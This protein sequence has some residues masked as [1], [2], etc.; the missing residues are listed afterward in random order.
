MYS[1]KEGYINN[2]DVHTLSKLVF[3]LGAGRVH[4]TDNID[5]SVGVVLNKTVGSKVKE[6]E[7]LAT[8]YYNKK[9]ADMEEIL[10]Q[11]FKI[12]KRKKRNKK[13]IIKTI[14]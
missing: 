12:D 5:Y 8:I 14:K 11:C 13:I 10:K 7:L 3:D 1:D 2:I 9:V 6:K 4:K